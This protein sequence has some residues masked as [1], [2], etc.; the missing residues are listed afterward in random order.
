MTI[1][2][3][4]QPHS[5]DNSQ[6]KRSLSLLDVTS[7]GVNGVV[8]QGIFFIPA[9]AVSK[10]GPAA[11]IA[12][13]LGA[14]IC[15]LISLCFAEVGSRF[16]GT[17]GAYL[18]AREAFGDFVGFEVGWMTCIVA[19]T[20]WAALANGLVTKALVPLL[21]AQW[22][23]TLSPLELTLAP[24]ILM[25][26]L[27]VINLWG[28]KSGAGLSTALT[29][30]KLTPIFLLIIVGLPQISTLGFTPFA[31]QGWSSL[32]EATLMLLYAYVGFETLVVPAGEMENPKRSIPL[33][34]ITVMGLVALIYIAVFVVSIGVLPDVAQ[35]KNP[36]AEASTFVLGPIGGVLIAYGILCSVL[37]TNAAAAVVSPRRI[38]AFAEGG[39]LPRVLARV[40]P[41]TG[42]PSL[43][44]I[45]L[46]I[47]SSLLSLSGSFEEL[48]VMSVVARFCQYIPTC[49]A[50]ITLRKRGPAPFTLPGG[51]LIP[52]ITLIA[53]AA[54]LQNSAPDKLLFGFY[55][56]L[57][58]AVVYGM[59][60][61]YERSKRSESER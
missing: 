56:L 59:R 4:D 42:A 5:Q 21:D 36:I 26:T 14:I 27:S 52:V 3:S 15:V 34:L 48:A 50:V 30:L 46:L 58:G 10:V 39:H 49:V 44:I 6:L 11:L 25:T 23:V 60:H 28:A 54:L 31:P 47:G 24:I 57:V 38:F 29:V 43:A 12:L 37:G 22:G 53:C 20:A 13:I 35:S 9:I 51:V 18:Y 45:T 41:K 40:N 19:M 61:L 8:G 16:K 55:A 33:A 17:G 2:T 7:L 32:G 1:N